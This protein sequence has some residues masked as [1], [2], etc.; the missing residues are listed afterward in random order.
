MCF[1]NRFLPKLAIANCS[2][3]RCTDPRDTSWD[4]VCKK[5]GSC[6]QCR[7]TLHPLQ[8]RLQLLPHQ[9]QDRLP[10]RETSDW[11]WPIASGAEGDRRRSGRERTGRVQANQDQQGA[12]RA[13]VLKEWSGSLSTAVELQELLLQHEDTAARYTREVEHA[14]LMDEMLEHLCKMIDLDEARVKAASWQTLLET[15]RKERASIDNKGWFEWHRDQ[16]TYGA[17]EWHK[18]T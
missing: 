8:C 6:R 10:R 1:N 9:Q 17:L 11:H 14:S 16:A 3:A 15:L 2:L 4:I 5:A 7:T 18:A 12:G 13:G